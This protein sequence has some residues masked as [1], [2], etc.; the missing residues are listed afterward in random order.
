VELHLFSK[1]ECPRDLRELA[2]RSPGL[3]VV[4][5]GELAPDELQRELRELDAGWVSL[6]PGFELPAFPSK[7]MAYICAGIPVLFC[8]PPLP[9]Y[10][11]WL[12]GTGL[13]LCADERPVQPSDITGLAEGF[14]SARSLYLRSMENDWF[15]LEALL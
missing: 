4:E 13:G 5:R 10:R 6:D 15:G 1:D 9:G 3:A 12:L 11:R 2:Q 14:D 8:G 7:A